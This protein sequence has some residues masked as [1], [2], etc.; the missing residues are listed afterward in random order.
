MGVHD[1]V[2]VAQCFLPVEQSIIIVRSFRRVTIVD[3]EDHLSGC[4]CTEH[5]V[6]ET[7]DGVHHFCVCGGLGYQLVV[8]PDAPCFALGVHV[9]SLR[10]AVSPLP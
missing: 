9:G 4:G 8:G 5:A 2:I 7:N 3:R 1:F 10:M 6:S